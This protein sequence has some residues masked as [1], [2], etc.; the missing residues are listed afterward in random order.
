M[1]NWMIYFRGNSADYNEWEK[2]GNP[3]WG[4][5]DVATYFRNAEGKMRKCKKI[6]VIH[7]MHDNLN[8]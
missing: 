2:L 4:W 6:F 5:K 1:L 3:G 7:L 8:L